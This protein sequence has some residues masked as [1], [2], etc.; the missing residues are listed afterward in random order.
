MGP[1][2]NCIATTRIAGHALFEV[3]PRAFGGACAGLTTAF[4]LDLIRGK[5]PNEAAPSDFNG[6][7]RV[8]AFNKCYEVFGITGIATATL[9][10]TSRWGGAGSSFLHRLNQALVPITLTLLFGNAVK[11]E[12][13]SVIDKIKSWAPFTSKLTPSGSS[14]TSDT[15]NLSDTTSKDAA[16]KSSPHLKKKKL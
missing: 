15:Q 14:D 1:I 8:R 13:P 9:L 10:T 3:A 7:K 16:S 4:A 11:S 5:N 12:F 6:N 2:I